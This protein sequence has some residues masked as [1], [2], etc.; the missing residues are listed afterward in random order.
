M[1]FYCTSTGPTGGLNALGSTIPPMFT[2][3]PISH[4][5]PQATLMRRGGITRRCSTSAAF[6]DYT[7]HP[8]MQQHRRDHWL[9]TVEA[10][11]LC[12]FTQQIIHGLKAR[13]SQ[14]VHPFFEEPPLEC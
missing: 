12:P 10:I 7:S 11:H 13:H 3:G 1:R 4:E 6:S 9:L 14:N 8:K 5:Q 2:E